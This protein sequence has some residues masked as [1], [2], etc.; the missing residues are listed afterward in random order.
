MQ[1]AKGLSKSS[2]TSLRSLRS[3]RLN[4]SSVSPFPDFRF[5]PR[6]SV[7]Q[8]FS[9]SAFSLYWN[10]HGL[11]VV[12]LAVHTCALVWVESVRI[13]YCICPRT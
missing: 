2:F 3:L 4:D 13:R 1:K 6:L 7:S 9:L 5:S 12:K 11:S 8:R 10:F